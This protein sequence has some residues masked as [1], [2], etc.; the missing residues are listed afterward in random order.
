M[1]AEKNIANLFQV[2]K[3]KQ[4]YSR[5]VSRIVEMSSS[6]WLKNEIGGDFV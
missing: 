6:D 3:S 4:P 5:T 2:E 1:R